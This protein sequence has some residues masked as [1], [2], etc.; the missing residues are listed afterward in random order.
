MLKNIQNIINFGLILIVGVI[1]IYVYQDYQDKRSVK[2]YVVNVKELRE[3]KMQELKVLIYNNG[4]SSKKEVNSM[5]QKHDERV[6]K[7]IINTAKKNNIVIYPKGAI[8]SSNIV[9]LT[10]SIIKVLQK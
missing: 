5:L 1:G 6:Y 9:D 3:K 4:V 7:I 2:H 8:F 10:P